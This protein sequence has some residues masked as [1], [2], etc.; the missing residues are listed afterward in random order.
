MLIVLNFFKSYLHYLFYINVYAFF[1]VDVMC[2][3][4]MQSNV[5]MRVVKSQ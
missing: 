4:V 3:E 1:Y 2:S 5:S